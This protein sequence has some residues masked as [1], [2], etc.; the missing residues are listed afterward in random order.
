MKNWIS[1]KFSGK[2]KNGPKSPSADISH[3]SL[4]HV[5]YDKIDPIYSEAIYER[6]NPT[7]SEAIY[8]KINPISTEAIYEKINPTSTEAIYEKINPTSTEAMYEKVNPTSTNANFACIQRSYINL[9]ST[10]TNA[11]FACIKRSYINLY[12]SAF[13]AFKTNFEHVEDGRSGERKVE[14]HVPPSNMKVKST[15]KVKVEVQAP[16]S[17]M[18]RKS[19][20]RGASQQVRVKASA[21]LMKQRRN[22]KPRPQTSP[23]HPTIPTSGYYACPQTRPSTTSHLPTH[24]DCPQTKPSTTSNPPGS[25]SRSSYHTPV[26]QIRSTYLPDSPQA[27]SH[28]T[29]PSQILASHPDHT[30]T[31]SFHPNL[32]KRSSFHPTLSSTII[33]PDP[34]PAPYIPDEPYI[35]PVC[36][37]PVFSKRELLSYID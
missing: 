24:Y 1:K 34:P 29:D 20:H 19:I 4:K 36:P 32:Q 13:A 5:I 22:Y 27:F 21:S 23:A 6:I 31:S 25:Q 12:S 3:I 35:F 10:S 33:C 26:Q 17:S 8:E 28:L 7:S 30:H 11:N 2:N 16:P 15:G 9:Y 14:V 18:K 37:G